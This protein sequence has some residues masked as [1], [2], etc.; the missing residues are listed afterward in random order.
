ML[1]CHLYLLS[2]PVW[3]EMFGSQ[4]YG[5]IFLRA[6][7]YAYF[8][9][10][11]AISGWAVGGQKLGLSSLR[12]GFLLLGFRRRSQGVL[13]NRCG[14]MD[15][16]RLLRIS[17]KQALTLSFRDRPCLSRQRCSIRNYR[18][19]TR[20]SLRRP[21]L[22]ARQFRS[23]K[24][25][26]KRCGP[27]KRQ[28]R[29]PPAFGVWPRLFR[30]RHGRGGCDSRPRRLGRGLSADGRRRPRRSRPRKRRRLGGWRRQRWP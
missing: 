3:P 24:K 21:P 23:V 27:G 5:F 1:T 2:N 9:T 7:F 11:F 8:F 25:N 12:L 29:E 26:C 22:S 28:R 15:G 30:K 19:L 14:F 6:N 20:L 18:C 10:E 13:W 4:I 17:D 16:F